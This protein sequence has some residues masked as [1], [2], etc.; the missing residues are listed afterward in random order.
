MLGRGDSLP[1]HAPIYL[2]GRLPE[3][4]AV[5]CGCDGAGYSF[6]VRRIGVSIECPKCGRTA[7]A[8]DLVADYHARASSSQAR[9]SAG[10][11]RQAL[12]LPLEH[13][14]ADELP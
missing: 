10:R 1:V 6:L 12:S 8:P 3:G 4:Y 5:V 9:R 7:L 14:C 11:E 13:A 2:D